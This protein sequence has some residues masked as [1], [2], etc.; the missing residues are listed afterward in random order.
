MPRK[1]YDSWAWMPRIHIRKVIPMNKKAYRAREVNR[2]SLEQVLL[3][4]EGLAARVGVDVGKFVVVVVVRWS[5]GRFERPWRVENPH[6]LRVLTGLLRELGKGRE[7]V[8]ALEP[9]G[10]YGDALRQALH[11]AGLVVHRVSAK[12]AC[13]YAEVFDGVPSQHDGKDAA[14]IAELSAIG[15]SS[16]WSYEAPPEVERELAYCVDWM[17]AQ[18][19]LRSIWMGRLEALLARHWP[20]ATRTMKITRPTLLRA[21]ERYGGPQALVRDQRAAEQL[22]AWGGRYLRAATIAAL[23]EG[24]RET[25]GIRQTDTD[26]RQIRRCA[27]EVLKARDEVR[28]CQREL[29]KLAAGNPVLEAHGAAVGLPTACVLWAHLGNP[30]SYFCGAAYRK[31]MG[32]NLKERSSGRYQGQLKI[33]K[34]GSSQVRRWLY[35]AAMR[36]VK[37][38]PIAA[39]HR[40]QKAKNS[41]A[42]KRSLIG[43]MRRL[44]LALYH[45]AVEGVPFEEWR[46]FP[47]RVRAR[48]RRQAESAARTAAAANG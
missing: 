5:D 46:V 43:V 30:Q 42:A 38:G 34:R 13:D 18:H 6:E 19:K 16:V 3:D 33:T 40:R 25:V 35:F 44:A 1:C 2:V 23:L 22:A 29:R 14:V 11:D 15:K 48:C 31:A 12:A 36:L 21:L 8:V 28:R 7:M 10:T 24:A 32:L 41:A 9:T 47:G 17:D 27:R 26:R 20:E 45:V 39:W 4:R 37:Q